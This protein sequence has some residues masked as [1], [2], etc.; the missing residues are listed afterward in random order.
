M[1][2]SAVSRII[3]PSVVSSNSWA[4][5]IMRAVEMMR[6]MLASRVGDRRHD[7]AFYT[8]W[9]KA[10]ILKVGNDF[11]SSPNNGHVTTAS[12]RPFRARSGL[13]QCSKNQSL[14]DHLVGERQK[15]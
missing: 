3:A 13:V 8:A 12:A 7:E 1:V 11:R 15:T 2:L 6:P 10:V 9:S 4:F 14:F 5:R